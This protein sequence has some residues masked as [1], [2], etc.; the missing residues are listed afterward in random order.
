MLY[1]N[2]N[3]NIKLD[4]NRVLKA[5]N[6]QDFQESEYNKLYE[7]F[8]NNINP[9]YEYKILNINELSINEAFMLNLDCP[10]N[11]K[12]EIII[13][14]ICTIG[15]EINALI[16]TMFSEGNYMNALIIDAMANCWI[17]SFMESISAEIKAEYEKSG[18]NL[19]KHRIPG[20]DI[21]ISFQNII[22]DKIDI[23]VSTN[24]YGI[25]SPLKSASFVILG[26]NEVAAEF[27]THH[28]CSNCKNENCMYRKENLLDIHIV[29]EGK[30]TLLKV[31][32]D[33]NLMDFLTENGY[34][35][36]DGCG[37][38]G[39]CGKCR[40]LVNGEGVLSCQTAVKPNMS[41]ALYKDNE[42]FVFEDT[43]S[44][45]IL[46]FKK[47]KGYGIAVDLGSTTVSIILIDLYNGKILAQRSFLNPQRKYGS[48]I[49]MRID[50]AL[51]GKLRELSDL[52][53]TEMYSNII[54]MCSTIELSEIKKMTVS[55]N[56][57]MMHLLLYK[58]CLSL[59]VYPF[60][61][62]Q[63]I[64]GIFK[65]NELFNDSNLNFEIY[66][67][68]Y[69]A[70]FVGGDVTAGI[71]YLN[72]NYKNYL[73]IDAGTNGEIVLN[74]N[75]RYYITSTA[76]GPA[77][78]GVNISCGMG[79]VAGAIYTVKYNNDVFVSE[80]ILNDEPIGICGSGM[81]DLTA[82]LLHNN[83]IDETGLLRKEYFNDGILLS[84]KNNIKFI[85]NDIRQIQLSK[86][87][88]R[89]GIEAVIK[90]AGIEYDDIAHLI[91]AGGF[92]SKINTSNAAAIGL[93]SEQLKNRAI[94]MGNT[95]L[96]GSSEIL[97]EDFNQISEKIKDIK[98]NSVYLN[99][100]DYPLFDD[101]FLNEINFLKNK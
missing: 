23:G 55:G 10:E 51:K 53:R 13:A 29:S 101:M 34:K 26:G 12:A 44:L 98:E 42:K 33:K 93:I 57:V 84:R 87:A 71:F 30:S 17:F 76:A 56:T 2:L 73:L 50:W 54:S 95:S 80:T 47:S 49:I 48:D 63:K 16:N 65:A 85:Q 82:E 68:P 31:P 1:L 9:M 4:K 58:D 6:F 72:R 19:S 38:K 20:E 88:I 100:S 70:G 97:F 52:I 59:S 69:L 78:E 39:I 32:E 27:S 15:E 3:F 77:F 21:D 96:K 35:V 7:I 90:E 86:A 67:T 24:S 64:E 75:G 99:L 45:S 25:L 14:A 5:L 11:S 81:I 41:V 94:A 83:I 79:S 92:G 28:N 46:D 37:K 43:I 8:I 66:A 91:L 36:T 18:M 74:I 89:A 22:T 60:N 40:V 61:I 62:N